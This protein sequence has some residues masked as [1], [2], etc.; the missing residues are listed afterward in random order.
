MR[1]SPALCSALSP[2]VTYRE[3]AARAG[4]QISL[5]FDSTLAIRKFHYDDDVPRAC[6]GRVRT[7]SVVVV[8][9]PPSDVR[10]ESRVVPAQIVL[11]PQR[12]TRSACRRS[13][14]T[15]VQDSNLAGIPRF[16]EISR[17]GEEMMATVAFP[18]RVEDREICVR[19]IRLNRLTIRP[20]RGGDVAWLAVHLRAFALRRTTFAWLANRSS[21]ARWQA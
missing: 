18:E 2:E 19:G 5:E 8:T 9:Q 17:V 14:T 12:C 16:P 6:S 15:A 1:S 21:R 7:A 10:R 20:S 11:A 13:P 4:L 3:R